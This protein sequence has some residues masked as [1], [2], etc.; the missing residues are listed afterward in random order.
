MTMIKEK[1]I[2]K[3]KK[4]ERD[5]YGL[6]YD[7]VFK[8]VFC[9]EDIRKKKD[10]HLLE[11]LINEITGNH[12]K[13]IQV[14][15][16][17]LS[18]QNV[19]E[20]TKRLDMLVESEGEIVHMELNT[21]WD[22][23]TRIRNNCFFFSFYSQYTKAGNKY[24]TK[25]RFIHISL[26][27]NVGNKGE[28]I[29]SNNWNN[30]FGETFPNLRFINV[31]LEKHKKMW[32]D[33]VA[34]GKM[35]GSILTLLSLKE[36]KDVIAYSNSVDDPDI[37]ECVDKLMTL[38]E[39]TIKSFWNITPEEDELK[40]QRTRDALS[41]ARGEEIGLNKGRELGLSEGRELGLSEGRELGISEGRELGL[42]EGKISVARNLLKLNIAAE[43]ISKATGLSREKIE[44]LKK[45]E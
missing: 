14:I 35:K 32:Y 44:K 10:F 21:S 31:N 16:P 45:N 22:I 11:R 13:V 40:L 36:K 5:F 29:D 6:E 30:E 28:I 24:D 27:Y 18:V 23:G 1:K 33:N 19:R 4:V 43:D 42:S 20:R 17:E 15:S 7:K 26:N 25:K 38:N 9:D 2:T 34:K 3:D 12:I 39:N 8:A 37:W 41:L